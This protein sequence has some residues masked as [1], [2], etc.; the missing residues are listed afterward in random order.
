ME[1]IELSL[2][3]KFKN[4]EAFIQGCENGFELQLE[5]VV[6]TIL[7]LGPIKI[8]TLAGPTCSG[9]TTA[10]NMI[11]K[12]LCRAGKQTHLVSIDDFF[13]DRERLLKMSKDKGL[14]IPDYDSID[15]ID[16]EALKQFVAEVLNGREAHCPLFDFKLGIR[17][18]YK[19]VQAGKDDVFLFEGIQTIYPE[20]SD[21][22]MKENAVSIYISPESKIKVA[23]TVFNPCE[24]RFM[25][26]LV[27][28]YNRRGMMPEATF[29]IWES[30]RTNEDK[31]IFPYAKNCMHHID[32]T[33]AYEIGVLAP[34]LKNILSKITSD[35]KYYKKA[36]EIL[37]KISHVTSISDKYISEDSLYKEFI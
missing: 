17:S 35:S 21:V 10:A 32:S 18:G 26:R 8:I 13:F 29:E 1:G 30:V 23:D 7:S 4:T 24:I 37:E 27:R 14:E 34:H 12:R 5:R 16:F 25:R 19:L 33:M 22:L 11:I 2:T 36:N 6:E 9:K 15:T 31:N 28:D 3:N 20:I